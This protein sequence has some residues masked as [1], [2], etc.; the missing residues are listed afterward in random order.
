MSLQ[1]VNSLK[2]NERQVRTSE[3]GLAGRVVGFGNFLKR[4]GFKSFQNN[5]E[6]A[7]A[8][9]KAVGVTSKE[10]FYY[11]LR[12]NLVKSDIE[13]EQFSLLFDEYWRMQ[14]EPD[15]EQKKNGREAQQNQSPQEGK[16]QGEKVVDLQ[17]IT[18]EEEVEAQKNNQHVYIKGYGYS[19]IS[20][21]DNVDLNR[22]DKKD[23]LV[24]KLGLQ[25][26]IA[27]FKTNKSRRT[28]T[29][30]HR[31]GRVDFPRIIRRSFRSGGIPLDFFYKEKKKRL[32]R[33]IIIADVSGS[34]DRYV[35]FVIPFLL[36][37]RGVGPRAEVFV[38]STQ[39]S[40]VTFIIRHLSIEKALDRLAKEV[41]EWSGGTRIGFSLQQFNQKHAPVLLN[42]RAV[43]LILSDGWDL[44]GKEVL[45]R[46]M[47]H[48]SQKAHKVLWL[49]P[50]A[51]DPDYRPV[52]KGMQ[53]VLP[54][55]DYLLPANSLES[56]KV[57]G[58]LL[59]R[60]MI[61]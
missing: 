16:S 34:M 8:G 33:L 58:K 27:S 35:R 5:I 10:D 19:P 13:W 23:I 60:L 9:L 36:G 56:L 21:I 31:Q 42:N 51:G 43:V 44:G 30:P 40:H 26:I 55:V 28:R 17:V 53:V 50:L 22:F 47:E 48:I 15:D 46:A 32:K 61:H 6:D 1:G 2:N 59:S 39:L 54:Y 29:S 4:H 11:V 18:G 24:A 3:M 41:P 52:C 7:I 45:R 14:G 12:A 38:F 37:L 49:N 20:D 25:R 57:V